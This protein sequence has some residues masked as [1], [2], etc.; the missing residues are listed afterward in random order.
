MKSDIIDITVT[1]RGSSDRAVLVDYGEKETVWL[2]LSQ[3]E[4]APNADGRTHTVTLPQWLAEE[5][6]M[7]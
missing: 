6:E 2:P 5:R 4:L 3:I 7:V 1:I